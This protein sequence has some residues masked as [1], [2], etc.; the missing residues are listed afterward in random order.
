MTSTTSAAPALLG[1]RS[2]TTRTADCSATTA[3][4]T[5]R[6]TSPPVCSNGNRDAERALLAAGP[7]AH[8]QDGPRHWRR[9]PGRRPAEL[10]GGLPQRAPHRRHAVRPA[11]GEQAVGQIL[12]PSPRRTRSRLPLLWPVPLAPRCPRS[13][14]VSATRSS[15]RSRRRSAASVSSEIEQAADAPLK[16][17]QA[18]L[19]R[20]MNAILLAREIRVA[21][22]L[23]N[24][25][26]W[27]SAN[28]QTILAA[29]RWNGGASSDPVANIH[30]ALEASWGDVTGVAM[31]LPAYNASRATRRCGPTTPT[32]TPRHPSPPRA[33]SARCSRSRRSSLGRMQVYHSPRRRSPR[34]GQ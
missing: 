7:R 11:A 34:L 18:T 6:R 3:R 13:P 22:M 30:A 1:G 17:R 9:A 16:I 4:T 14:C 33:R 26:N 29:A 10:R 20:I 25:S 27:N 8:R 24:A 2:P 32:R 21:N 28:V 31:S 12:T 23:Q 5:W 19:R 15:P